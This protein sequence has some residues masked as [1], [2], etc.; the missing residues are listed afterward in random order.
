[1]AHFHRDFFDHRSTV[2]DLK[3][4]FFLI[5]GFFLLI[6]NPYEP[7][8][9]RAR[10]TDES[11]FPAEGE[12]REAEPVMNPDEDFGPVEID[13]PKPRPPV[14][15]EPL[16]PVYKEPLPPVVVEPLEEFVEEPA[17]D[18]D[19]RP[20]QPVAPYEPVVPWE[21]QE[22]FY[23][24]QP[25]NPY[26]A[27]DDSPIEYVEY[28]DYGI[29][30]PS[31][32]KAPKP[33]ESK[34]EVPKVKVKE[35]GERQSQIERM[36]LEECC[37]RT[38]D[39]KAEIEKKPV[40]IELREGIRKGVIINTP[41]CSM[42]RGVDLF[43]N[44]RVVPR[45]GL[46]IA[47]DLKSEPVNKT[48]VETT[49]CGL[50]LYYYSGPNNAEE[51][52]QRQSA[53]RG[54]QHSRLPGQAGGGMGYKMTI[55]GNKGFNF[56]AAFTLIGKTGTADVQGRAKDGE[57]D[58]DRRERST[59]SI[60]ALPGET[61]KCA[62]TNYC[63]PTAAE[64]NGY[65]DCPT[66]SGG[67][68]PDEDEKNTCPPETERISEKGRDQKEKRDRLRNLLKG[69]ALKPGDGRKGGRNLKHVNEEEEWKRLQESIV[70]MADDLEELTGLDSKFI[71]YTAGRIGLLLLGFLVC[72]QFFVKLKAGAEALVETL[73]NVPGWIMSAKN[74]LMAACPCIKYC[75]KRKSGGNRAGSKKGSDEGGSKGK[76]SLPKSG[77]K[78]EGMDHA[79]SDS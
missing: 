1:M 18:I 63:I 44:F 46:G 61:T 2:M 9:L 7:K 72:L 79:G 48:Q 17:I 58:K 42:P 28:D 11:M 70:S 27:I 35:I 29:Y 24:V 20:S 78:P 4:T 12:I 47:H 74:G 76:G 68:T 13:V 3:N 67:T 75:F 51:A 49:T 73:S 14:Y 6:S 57:S 21:P 32:F 62:G 77:L 69:I 53:C 25:L 71:S 56:D 15:E 30:S 36:T 45:D 65:Y 39:R 10:R 23:P 60:R 66:T 41:F 52:G 55:E 34:D 19:E 37:C 64:C 16:L 38:L 22:P 33:V 8:A 31:M 50:D 54:G 26:Q 40:M 59:C 5:V 43:C